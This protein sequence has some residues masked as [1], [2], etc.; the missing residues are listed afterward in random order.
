M[1][2]PLG[3]KFRDCKGIAVEPIARNVDALS[4]NVA[5]N[6]LAATITVI[7]VAL[8]DKVG[9]V[10]MLRDNNFGGSTGNAK[11]VM[12]AETS[13]STHEVTVELLDNVWRDSGSPSVSFIKIDVEGYEYQVLKGGHELIKTCRPVVYGEFHNVLMP[14]NGYDFHDVLQ[15]FKHNDYIVCQY[16]SDGELVEVENPSRNTGNAFF[17]PG[18]RRDRFP[19]RLLN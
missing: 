19:L 3:S 10:P 18:E 11:I 1:S 16:V 2:V 12:D 9:T 17:I 13:T 8:G 4:R 7:P 15:L 5:L 6:S 14:Q